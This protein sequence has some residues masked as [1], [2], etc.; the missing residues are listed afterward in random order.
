MFF[1][2]KVINMVSITLSVP[3]EV[4]RKMD[5]FSEIN[6]SGFVREK[7]IEKAS[8]L[9]WKEEMLKK[10]EEEEEFTDW[11][12]KLIRAGRKGRL[13]ELKKKGLI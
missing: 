11:N 6:W 13:E 7:I 8:Q 12:V 1:N 2:V 10:L 3:E 4:K 5:H 9:S